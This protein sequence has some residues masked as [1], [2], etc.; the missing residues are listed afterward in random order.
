MT[1]P[2]DLAN[3][4][5]QYGYL[6]V[7]SLIFLQ[8][9][10]VPNPVPNEA[11][12]LFAG[13][14]ASEKILSFPLILIAGISADFV[15]TSILYF[16]FYFFGDRILKRAPRWLPIEKIEII[17]QRVAKRGWWGVFIGRLLPY[18]RGYASVAAGLLKIPPKSFLSSVVITAI[19]WSGGYVIIGRLLGHQWNKAMA[20]LK[21]W[22][23]LAILA[24]LIFIFF[25]VAPKIRQ[26]IKKTKQKL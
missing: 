2:P 22:Q 16:I 6:A 1:I 3:Y 11:I 24:V 10:G 12:L 19:I 21:L 8:E 7:F 17:K 15:G 23:I 26:S 25:Y 5:V 18:L 14:L 20:S 13:Y 4:I 9:L